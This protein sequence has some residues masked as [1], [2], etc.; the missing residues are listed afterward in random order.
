MLV[1]WIWFAT[2]SFSDRVKVQLLQHF[3]D[4][5]EIYYA[6]K[7]AFSSVEGL[8]KEQ[9]ESLEEKSLHQAEA[10]LR[11]CSREK[12]GVL[13]F[14]DASYPAR[15]KNISDPPMVLYYKGRLP[16]FDGSPLIG[17]VGTRKASAYGMTTEE[18]AASL[19]DG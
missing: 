16:D 14:Q 6:D 2:R 15:L 18:Y 9:L 4:P 12:I 19:V 11:Q 17:V 1:H 13:T 5:E 8:T 7:G 10:V 3:S